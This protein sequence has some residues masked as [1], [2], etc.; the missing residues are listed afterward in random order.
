[1]DLII[2][3]GKTE[4]SKMDL[5][6]LRVRKLEDFVDEYLKSEETKNE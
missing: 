1:M 6:E 3:K 5:L 4:F 2:P